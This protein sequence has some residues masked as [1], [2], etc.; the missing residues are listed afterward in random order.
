[1]KVVDLEINASDV[2]ETGEKSEKS[3]FGDYRGLGK[4]KKG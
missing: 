3:D 1:M 4:K 2:G